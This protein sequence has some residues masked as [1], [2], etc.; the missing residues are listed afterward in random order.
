MTNPFPYKVVLQRFLWAVLFCIT[1]LVVYYSGKDST[2]Q[3][4]YLTQKDSLFLK[5]SHP[6]KDTLAKAYIQLSHVYLIES[7]LDSADHYLQLSWPHIRKGSLLNADWLDTKGIVL[8]A[9]GQLTPALKHFQQALSI[10]DKLGEKGLKKKAN[11]KINEGKAYTQLNYL[12]KAIASYQ[13]ALDIFRDIP[14]HQ[15]DTS[16]LSLVYNNTGAVYFYENKLDKAQEYY[17][18][19]RTLAVMK[20]G[21]DHPSVGQAL[22]NIGLVRETKGYYT[23][24]IYFYEQ[25]LSIYKKRFGEHHQLI[26]EAYGGLGS[27]YLNRKEPDRA[28]YYFEKDLVTVRQLYGNDHPDMAWGYESLGWAYLRLQKQDTAI[29]LLQTSLALRKQA[30]NGP[31]TE[32]AD[33]L[34]LLAEAYNNSEMSISLT[35]QALEMEESVTTSPTFTKANALLLLSEWSEQSGKLSDALRWTDSSLTIL[36]KLVIDGKHPNLA[37]ARLRKSALHLK[38]DEL[39][40]AYTWADKAMEATTEP[41]FTGNKRNNDITAHFLFEQEYLQCLIAKATIQQAY[42]DQTKD[43]VH[44]E[45]ILSIAQ[46]ALP[47][48]ARIQYMQTSEDA[49]LAT[50]SLFSKVYQTG[51]IQ[52]LALFQHY[53]RDKYLE[54]AFAFAERIKNG[55][56]SNAM[57]SL[58]LLGVANIPESTIRRDYQL[59]K[60]IRYIK[61]MMENTDDQTE[62]YRSLQETLHH[63]YAEQERF[64]QNM[65]RFHPEYF[66]MKYHTDP[67]KREH[68]QEK[69]LGKN[70]LMMHLTKIDDQI[71]VWAIG[72]NIFQ[73]KQFDSGNWNLENIF[74]EIGKLPN[75]QNIIWIPD[76]SLENIY[77]E[78][79]KIDGQYMLEKYSFIYNSS[80]SLYARKPLHDKAFNQQILAFAPVTFN[81]FG[82]PDLR[83]SEEEVKEINK[84]MDI[85]PYLKEKATKKQFMS[86]LNDHSVIHLA[87]HAAMNQ[88]S[89]MK[90]ALY[91]YPSGQKDSAVVFAHELFGQPM[92]AQLVTLSACR[93]TEQGGLLE[94]ASGIAAAFAYNGCRNIL[95][96]LW[97]V[98]DKATKE[99]MTGFYRYLAEGKDKAAALRLSKLDYLKNTDRYGKDPKYWAGII[100]AGDHQPFHLGKSKWAIYWWIPA[101]LAFIAAILYNR[102]WWL[103]MR[104]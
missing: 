80:A 67:V 47:V 72:K 59:K 12:D 4:N 60:D 74:S 102:R 11:V 35:L 86:E 5:L 54:T 99:I 69:I 85:E 29:S 100:L 23:D 97:D 18:K 8:M 27:A 50:D 76:A 89:P 51:M 90:S 25:A 82:L 68:L 103:R 66:K 42:F 37:Q 61:S 2:A 43:I 64:F 65:R 87:T 44:R 6:D 63:L 45:R 83:H 28:I 1:G 55:S 30:Y 49:G 104:I 24:A 15:L 13:T 26:A 3:T 33:N 17:D 31:H 84:Y 21:K 73:C 46:S 7:R 56:L 40:M 95:M 94:G 81:I 70:N 14:Q 48:I 98:D 38:M 75:I 19:A 53:K 57:R 41:S 62:E 79:V 34:L 22:Y 10:C 77:P 52:A 88:M 58:D 101:L 91:F 71:V 9:Q 20:Y 78:S 92:R 32:I 96:S 93:T 16:Q 39:E 36:G